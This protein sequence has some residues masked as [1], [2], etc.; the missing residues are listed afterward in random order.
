MVGEG[1]VAGT[2]VVA[3]AGV[4]ALA[5]PGTRALSRPAGGERALPWSTQGIPLHS[6]NRQAVASN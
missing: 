1:R 2:G 6:P 4:V 5:V 3:G